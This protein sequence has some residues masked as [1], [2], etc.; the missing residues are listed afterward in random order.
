MR[1][2]DRLCCRWLSVESFGFCFLGVRTNMD[3]PLYINV[4]LFAVRE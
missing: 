3:T 2:V 1:Y 4:D